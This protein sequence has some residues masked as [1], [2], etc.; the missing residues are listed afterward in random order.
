MAS[1]LLNSKSSLSIALHFTL[2]LNQI[3][4]NSNFSI[5]SANIST[6]NKKQSIILRFLPINL[7]QVKSSNPIQKYHQ[8]ICLEQRHQ[9]PQF[10]AELEFLSPISHPPTRNCVQLTHQQ[11]TPPRQLDTAEGKRLSDQ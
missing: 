1:H 3:K 5:V 4:Q 11:R 8:Q 10:P 7:A 6:K 2:P 9:K